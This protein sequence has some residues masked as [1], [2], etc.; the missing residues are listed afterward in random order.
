MKNITRRRIVHNDDFLQ[1]PSKL[2]QVFH[3]IAA[4]KYTRLPEKTRPEYVPSRR[5][6]PIIYNLLLCINAIHLLV[7]QIRNG[8]RVLGQRCREQDTLVQFAHLL[9][10]LVH[11]RPLQYVNLVN[12]SIDFHGNYK[13]RVRNRLQIDNRD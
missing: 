8:V 1:V 10:E 12:G 4:V 5:E 13:V 6:E 11:E 7:Q 9:Q 3:V 2:I